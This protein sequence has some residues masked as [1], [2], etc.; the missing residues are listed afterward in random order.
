MTSR[1]ICLFMTSALGACGGESFVDPPAGAE[2]IPVVVRADGP[3]QRYH[4]LERE[5]L[6]NGM[7]NAVVLQ[8]FR[9]DRPGRPLGYQVKCGAFPS[10][11][12]NGA[13]TLAGMRASP[14]RPNQLSR[15]EDSDESHQITAWLCQ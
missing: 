3:G 4:L 9:N 15:S 7:V 12:N 10:W 13:E 2:P 11:H 14:A 6:P 5:V 8:S 1:L